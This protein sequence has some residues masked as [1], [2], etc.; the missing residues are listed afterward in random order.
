MQKQVNNSDVCRTCQKRFIT[1]SFSKRGGGKN[2]T[3]RGKNHT[4]RMSPQSN[5]LL[6]SLM[7]DELMQRGRANSPERN[8]K[9]KTTERIEKRVESLTMDQKM[10]EELLDEMN[11]ALEHVKSCPEETCESI[12]LALLELLKEEA[13]K[14]GSKLDTVSMDSEESK[15]LVNYL[16]QALKNHLL[17]VNEKGN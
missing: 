4:A 10:L 7:D 12:E 16:V 8:S 5:C 9:N 3:A 2:H 13:E 15:E 17:K 1:G 14:D 6:T 11:K